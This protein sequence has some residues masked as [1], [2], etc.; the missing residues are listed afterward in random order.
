[1]IVILPTKTQFESVHTYL[2]TYV[3]T[4]THM[5]AC[6]HACLHHPHTHPHTHTQAL[7][8]AI[9]AMSSLRVLH[10]DDNQIKT[11][12]ISFPQLPL[13]RICTLA[14]KAGVAV[15]LECTPGGRTPLQLVCQVMNTTVVYRR[16]GTDDAFLGWAAQ[17]AERRRVID[18]GINA[19]RLACVELLL[20]H[21]ADHAA[22]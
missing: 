4:Y 1:M 18:E 8:E 6:M 2:R 10:A 16:G 19:D 12:P 14:K 11:L 15:D 7:P 5:H 22:V 20:A 13:L 9:G 21:G 3:R 17:P